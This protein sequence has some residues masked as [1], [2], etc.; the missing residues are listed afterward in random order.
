[1]HQPINISHVIPLINILMGDSASIVNIINLIK[2]NNLEKLMAAVTCIDQ[3]RQLELW[4]SRFN[5]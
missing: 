3:R 5:S 2:K 4:N 1:M